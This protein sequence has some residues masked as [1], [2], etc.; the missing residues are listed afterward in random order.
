MNSTTKP[1]DKIN[2]SR[3]LDGKIWKVIEKLSEVSLKFS[4][5]L[6]L[7][8]IIAIWY[9]VFARISHISTKGV[10]ELGGYLLTW[11]SFLGLA[12]G[13]RKGRHIRVDI[14]FERVSKKIQT[15]FLVIGNSICVVFSLIITW[16]GIR[17]IRMFY[18]IKEYS[19]SLHIP[20]YMVY[21]GM[22]IGMILFAVEVIREIVL[23]IKEG[24]TA[25]SVSLKGEVDE[26]IE[27]LEDLDIPNK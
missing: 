15:I 21:I 10:V 23:A 20:L 27:V 12:S 1:V 11:I 16:E 6:L 8:V 2:C 18:E 25:I 13:L 4:A 9:Q 22:P 17:L 14:I 26:K 7:L 5:L 3:Q 19:L 24:K